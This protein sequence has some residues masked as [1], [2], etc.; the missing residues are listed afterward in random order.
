MCAVKVVVPCSG[1]VSPELSLMVEFHDQVAF[2]DPSEPIGQ[3]EMFRLPPETWAAGLHSLLIS[4]LVTFWI[5]P[6][7]TSKLIG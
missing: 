5:W 3:Y 4:P 7:V 2:T 1:A 6:F